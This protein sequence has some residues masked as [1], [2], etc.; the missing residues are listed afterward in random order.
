MAAMRLVRPVEARY[1]ASLTAISRDWSAAYERALEP[2]LKEREEA[3]RTDA[4]KAQAPIPLRSVGSTF[5]VLGLRI[6]AAIAPKVN[7]AFAKMASGV[8]AASVKS[9][10]VFKIDPE[11][12]GL[13][14][15]AAKKRNENIALVENAHRVYAQQVRQLFEDPANL[16]MRVE[17]L[18]DRLLER[19]DV[20]KSRA[21]LIARDQTLKLNG[22][23]AQ[24]QMKNAGVE[25]YTWS[26][27]LDERVREEHQV[28]EG[29]TFTWDSPP[30]P[31]HPGE[32]YQ[33]RCVAI[34]VIEELAGVF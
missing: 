1:V 16:G 5:D 23:L 25:A 6:H 17:T 15:F 29:Q 10:A 21:E 24:E 8:H 12:K 7:K 18:R 32:D 33:C 28:L 14:E 11:S 22:A 19:G 4:G 9:L 34:P 3:Q 26:T 13:A 20:S 27:S 30:S 2:F 31:G